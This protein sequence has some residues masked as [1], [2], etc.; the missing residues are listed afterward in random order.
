M[1][2]DP[3]YV[4]PTDTPAVAPRVPPEVEELDDMMSED[5]SVA[6]TADS[7]MLS[8]NPPTPHHLDI[9]MHSL[10]TGDY[11]AAREAERELERERERER[12]GDRGRHNRRSDN[13]SRGSDLSGVSSNSDSTLRAPR[14]GVH[15]EPSLGPPDEND[16]PPPP[17]Y[18]PL[19]PHVY[20]QGLPADLPED[21]INQ[22]IAAMSTPPPGNR[23]A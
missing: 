22:A 15:R 7:S 4:S 11:F 9:S 3:T 20:S 12:R 16:S 6:S 1:D 8:P 21:L 14:P 13:A 2:E 23:S 17:G 5:E 19:D 10:R 18:A